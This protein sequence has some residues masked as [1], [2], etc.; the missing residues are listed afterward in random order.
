MS[1]A[2]NDTYKKEDALADT[3][4]NLFADQKFRERL[5]KSYNEDFDDINLLEN[6][7][8]QKLI[9]RKNSNNKIIKEKRKA[10]LKIKN[11]NIIR[12]KRSSKSQIKNNNNYH[13]NFDLMG[14]QSE[15]ETNSD[16]D[17]SK[18]MNPEEHPVIFFYLNKKLQKQMYSF[19]RRVK[20]TYNLRCTDRQSKGTADYDIES[21]KVTINKPCTKNYENHSYIKEEIV[22]KKIR[23][24]EITKDDL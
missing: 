14:S 1:R 6:H 10:H 15:I 23:A 19:H 2:K 9:N 5:K 8:R 3:I 20:N 7:N 21:G 16:I 24:K 18:K 12:S 11:T 4:I 13:K 17:S 22:I